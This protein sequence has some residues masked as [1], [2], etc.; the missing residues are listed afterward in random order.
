MEN[1]IFAKG[2]IFKRPNPKAPDF[3]KGSLSIKVDEFMQFIN[4]NQVKGWVNINLKEGRAEQGQLGKYYAELDTWQPTAGTSQHPQYAPAPTQE[5][6]EAK[7]TSSI[8]F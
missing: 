5:E 3:V 4:D 7:P 2:L 8:P 1:K 6:Q